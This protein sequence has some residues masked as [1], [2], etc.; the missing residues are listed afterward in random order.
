MLKMSVL[1]KRQGLT[2]VGLV[3][4]LVLGAANLANARQGPLFALEGS[5]DPRPSIAPIDTQPAGQTYGRWAAEW[6][7]W[8]L[9]IP[10]AV[11]PVT[12][13][14]GGHCGQ[15]QVDKVWFLA[16]SFSPDSATRTS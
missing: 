6:W 1:G 8:A 14:T 5:G 3:T 10:G 9:G 11:N 4:G 15:R 16:G 13:T 12:D 7:Q 2:M